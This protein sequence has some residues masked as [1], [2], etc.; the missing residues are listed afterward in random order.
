MRRVSCSI[1]NA[2]CI[3]FGLDAMEENCLAQAPCVQEAGLGR[4]RPTSQS[5]DPHLACVSLPEHNFEK[6]M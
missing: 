2:G 4:Y 1:G 5:F 3:L 6:V